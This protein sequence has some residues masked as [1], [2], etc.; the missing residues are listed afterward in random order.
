MIDLAKYSARLAAAKDRLKAGFLKQVRRIQAVADALDDHA[1]TRQ[2]DKLR[3]K[4]APLVA[5]AEQDQDWNKQ[6]E[7]LSEWNF[8]S[9]SVLDPVYERKGER[10]GAKAR[11]YGI[12]VP[13]KPRDNDERS[14]DWRLSRIFG[15]WMP[16]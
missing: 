16:S 11:K 14:D 13:P 7:L 5:K 6:Q 2:V 10:L 3:Q 12:T 9:D 4:Y 1:A 15:F 8:D